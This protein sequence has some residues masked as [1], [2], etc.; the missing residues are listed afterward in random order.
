M[1][2]LRWRGPESS[3]VGL[4]MVWTLTMSVFSSPAHAIVA[5]APTVLCLRASCEQCIEREGASGRCVK[6][7]VIRACKL[8]IDPTPRR[9]R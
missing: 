9:P 2:K 7:G 8:P 3:V 1:S 6:C 4:T 5:R